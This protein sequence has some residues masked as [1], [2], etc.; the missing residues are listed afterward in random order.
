MKDKKS[1]SGVSRRQF[2]AGATAATAA[3]SIG[4]PAVLRAQA[5]PIKV[6]VLHPVTGPLA[7]SGNQSRAGALMAIDAINAAGGI[8]SMGGAKLEAV[9]GDAQSKPDV[10]AAEVEK[11]NEAGVAAIVGPFASAI[12]LA[13]TQAAAKH[14]IPHVVDVGVVDQVVT[15]GLKNTFRFGPGITSIVDTAIQNL[16]AL[17][18]ESKTPIKTV[19]IVHEES[20]F[21]SG[22]AKTLN[23]RLPGMGL[24]IVETISHANPTRDFGTIALKL[25]GRN[26]DLI[27]PSNYYDEY[28]LLARTMLQQKISPKAIYSILGGGASSMRF[29]QEFNDAA[30]YVIDTNHWV[31][32]R[33]PGSAALMKQ[34]EAK[35]LFFTYEVFL[36]Y[37]CVRLLADALERAKSAKREGIIDALAASTWAD[38]IMPY[39]PTKFV[40]GQNQSARVVNTQIIGKEIK[41]IF[42]KEVAN[43]APVFPM[44]KRG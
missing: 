11:M 39:G 38:T 20:A 40:N 3:A 8:K 21:G 44:P 43:A 9:L 29:V 14:N 37:D 13:T 22:M 35:K 5:A 19:A 18:K 16:G 7:Y 36:N 6:G 28:V 33:K 41:L 4:F 25:K 10:G 17:I 12:A 15:R 2:V 26:P 30:Q 42:P 1:R 27:I 31:D 23:A 32:P 24:E 34:V